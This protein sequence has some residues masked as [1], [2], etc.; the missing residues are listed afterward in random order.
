MRPG[1]VS[2]GARLINVDP[3]VSVGLTA[4]RR[5]RAAYVKHLPKIA[6]R[7][8]PSRKSLK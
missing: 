7:S 5:R 4:A 3:F 1:R 2:V 8:V 6:A